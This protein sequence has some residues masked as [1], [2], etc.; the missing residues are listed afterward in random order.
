MQVV[1]ENI[2]L[3]TWAQGLGGNGVK[4]HREDHALAATQF[5]VAA[6]QC[7]RHIHCAEASL[8]FYQ[9]HP[10]QYRNR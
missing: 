3:G 4:Y 1:S 2:P 9:M 8:S 5:R 7:E 10:W 6:S